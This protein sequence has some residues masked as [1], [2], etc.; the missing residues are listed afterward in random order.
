MMGGGGVRVFGTPRSKWSVSDY[1]CK[2]K[3]ERKEGRKKE[4]NRKKERKE[5]SKMHVMI[6]NAHYCLL[7]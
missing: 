6:S 5:G 2:R 1:A 4:R 3:K 7:I